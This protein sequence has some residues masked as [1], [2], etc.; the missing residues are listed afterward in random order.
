MLSRPKIKQP[1]LYTICT[2]SGDAQ[3]TQSERKSFLE[4][5]MLI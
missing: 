2:S 4:G 1:V 3:K 5:T